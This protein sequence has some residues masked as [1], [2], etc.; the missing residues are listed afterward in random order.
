MAKDKTTQANLIL[1][2]DVMKQN[3]TC[4]VSSTSNS[5]FRYCLSNSAFSPTYEDIIRFIWSD[6]LWH[7]FNRRYG[8][9]QH[10]DL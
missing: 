4:G 9:W 3:I 5:P 1:E 10:F 2:H 6:I 8:I 7:R